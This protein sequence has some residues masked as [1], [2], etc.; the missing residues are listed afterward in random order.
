M[1][2]VLVV[3]ICQPT[4]LALSKLSV[5]WLLQRVFITHVFRVTVYLLMAVVVAWY[6]SILFADIFVCTPVQS[7]WDPT[8]GGNCGNM[9]LLD[10]I[11]PLPWILTDFAILAAPVPLVLKLHLPLYP[12]LGV[13]GVLLL[14]IATTV[15]SCVRYSAMFFA[16]G[17]MPWSSTSAGLLTV[18]EAQSAVVCAAL[19]ASKDAFG[20]FGWRDCSATQEEMGSPPP[21]GWQSTVESP[22][23]L[24]RRSSQEQIGSQRRMRTLE[25]CTEYDDEQVASPSDVEPPRHVVMDRDK[26][27][28]TAIDI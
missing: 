28:R 10:V 25:T 23:A 16:E 14:G 8:M 5:L 26:G 15:I 4:T 21:S 3:L 1:Q 13:L 7:H 11:S 2:Y 18:A 24:S 20:R 12:K 27:D 17:D 9:P 22:Q 19:L 6:L